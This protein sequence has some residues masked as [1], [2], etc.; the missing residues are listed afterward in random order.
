MRALARGATTGALEED[1]DPRKRDWREEGF[2]WMRPDT[3]AGRIF[4]VISRANYGMANWG[5][6]A[7]KQA[8]G[9]APEWLDPEAQRKF[10]TMPAPV[11]YI[12][13][14]NIAA[15]RGLFGK[16]KVFFE[17]VLNDAEFTRTWPTGVKTGLGL[18]GDVL[19]DPLTYLSGG[20]T[21]AGR[22]AK[23]AAA[24]AKA[25]QLTDVGIDLAGKAGKS[26]KLAT[27]H[28]K[29]IQKAMKAS[30]MS[31]D[32]LAALWSKGKPAQAEAGLRGMLNF[33]GQ[34][35]V[36]GTAQHRWAERVP[37]WLA[38]TPYEDVIKSSKVYSGIEKHVPGVRRGLSELLGAFTPGDTIDPIV[39]PLAQKAKRAGMVKEAW[40]GQSLQDMAKPMRKAAVTSGDPQD[41]IRRF[42][43]AAER[44]TVLADDVAESAARAARSAVPEDMQDFYRVYRSFWDEAEKVTKETRESLG[45]PFKALKEADLEYV[46]HKPN[47]D[48]IEELKR[49]GGEQA[50][51]VARKFRQWSTFDPSQQSR[52]LRG[53]TVIETNDILM[54]RIAGKDAGD[55][56]G[57]GFR[58]YTFQNPLFIEDPMEVAVAKAQNVGRL[59]RTE[60]FVKGV[61]GQLQKAMD[62][63]AGAGSRSE[64]LDDALRM[65]QE[66]WTE[67]WAGKF[68]AT[69]MVDTS[70]GPKYFMGWDHGAA[71]NNAIDAGYDVGKLRMHSGW[72]IGDQHFLERELTA[73]GLADQ[74]DW[75]LFAQK[76]AEKLRGAGVEDLV[77]QG[78]RTPNLRL[79]AQWGEGAQIPMA[80]LVGPRELVDNIEHVWRVANDPRTAGEVIKIYDKVLNTWRGYALMA[81]SY[82]I[83][84]AF[85]NTWQ[86]FLAGVN[87]PRAYGEALRFQR[88]VK[89]RAKDGGKALSEFFIDTPFGRKAGPQLFDEL[90]N[91]DLMGGFMSEWAREIDQMHQALEFGHRFKHGE[92]HLRRFNMAVGTHIENNARF[93]LYF[94]ALGKGAQ[95]VE[96]ADMVR[97]FLFDYTATGLSAFEETKVKRLTSFY[98]WTKNNMLLSVEQLAKQPGK[99]AGI[100][101]VKHGVEELTAAGSPTEEF[102]PEWLAEGYPVRIAGGE[103]PTYFS[104]QNWLPAMQIAELFEDIDEHHVP[105]LSWAMGML[106]PTIGIPLEQAINKSMF[107][108]S[109]IQKFPGERR[110]F[111]GTPMPPRLGHILRAVRPLS[112]ANRFL[113]GTHPGR[114]TSELFAGKVYPYDYNKEMLN[115]KYRKA[116]RLGQL[117][118]AYRRAVRKGRVR[119]AERLK[120]LYIATKKSVNVQ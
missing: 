42:M 3:P 26:L 14:S 98:R 45:L 16:A 18:A 62:D 95:P 84:N 7:V 109:E 99:Y 102:M 11:R 13:R 38:K 89:I 114:A 8:Q 97:H 67:R 75:F 82:H 61:K 108:E 66:Q 39:R 80:G 78:W 63:V 59:I 36:S 69:V 35:I 81:P 9:E 10:M 107:F 93:A 101:K 118:T 76:R 86:N 46:Y 43:Q 37:Y 120:V 60:Q 92:E 117:K 54:G 32:E 100:A 58:G 94:D 21:K 12:A 72:K 53:H 106:A 116:E 64:V 119:E 33:F 105:G 85:S 25:G 28:G 34:P 20:V 49:V 2:K 55:V 71:A 6:E 91:E 68:R 1:I 70:D 4:D 47:P 73:L 5:L 15:L 57:E 74:N 77:R 112:E 96:A 51:K 110:D 48:G 56:L 17:D 40:L 115:A 65:T 41:W 30:G 27:K 104:L 52:T 88:A 103:T 29:R 24:G 23:V 90:F 83:R 87:D 50:Q 113:R 111:L 31:A 44:P 19:L 79:P 22:G